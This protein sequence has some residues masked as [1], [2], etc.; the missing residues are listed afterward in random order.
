MNL[1]KSYS[2]DE[3][4]QNGLLQVE[5][6]A[7]IADDVRI[8]PYEDDGSSQGAIC[9]GANSRIRS[10]SIICSGVIVGNNTIIGHNVVVRRGVHLGDNT[11]ISHMVCIERDSRIGNNVRIS[12]LTH[13][14]GNCLVEDDV[15]I[16]ARVVTVNDNE[17]L[18]RK[19]PTLVAPTFRRGCRVGSGVT[20]L[21]GVEIGT[22]S[23]VGAGAVVTRNLP[24]NVVAFG[25]PARIHRE[26]TKEA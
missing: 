17:L 24:A 8:V 1:I 20:I 22:N 13:L 3:A 15:Q 11:V 12:A 14:T 4:L 2:P 9:V 10:G 7:Y 25:I 21:A 26:I 6:S 5:S 18:W 19:N 23:I 16:G